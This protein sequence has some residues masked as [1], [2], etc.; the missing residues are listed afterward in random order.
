MLK[1]FK[2]RYK[3]RLSKK[4]K[5]KTSPEHQR[6]IRNRIGL[7]LFLFVLIIT[8]L[9]FNYSQQGLTDWKSFDTNLSIFFL[10]NLNI[11]L[12]VVVTA[13]IVRNLVKLL[14]ERKRRKMGF[15]L[16]FKLTLA[17]MMVSSLPL[18]MFFFIAHGL[19]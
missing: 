9:A 12:L 11:L 13:L 4:E 17:F 18:I 10:I 14:Y 16:K 8:L 19:L 5:L 2:K 15:R 6:Q 1:K 7:I 3:D